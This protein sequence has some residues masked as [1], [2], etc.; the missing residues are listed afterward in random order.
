MTVAEGRRPRSDIVAPAQARR[1]A[2]QAGLPQPAPRPERVGAAITRSRNSLLLERTLGAAACTP[3][4]STHRR[5]SARRRSPID[6]LQ[7]AARAHRA[8]GLLMKHPP[9]C[10]CTCSGPGIRWAAEARVPAGRLGRG[11]TSRWS[12]RTPVASIRGSCASKTATI[13]LVEQKRLLVREPPGPPR[14]NTRARS[15]NRCASSKML[16]KSW[17]FRFDMVARERESGER[18]G[19]LQPLGESQRLLEQIVEPDA[20]SH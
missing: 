19:P 8:V 1:L 7:R 3:R 16:A 13:R 17:M 11:S 9:R 15:P 18:Q 5:M 4:R 12:R 14:R 2:R 10:Q 6:F 20:S